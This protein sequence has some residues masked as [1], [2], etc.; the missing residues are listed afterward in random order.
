MPI[1]IRELHIK[2]TIG[3]GGTQTAQTSQNVTN[4]DKKSMDYMI[5]QCVEK[6]LQVLRDKQE[7]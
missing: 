3:E 7:R 1:E 2:A 4:R 5:A 6:V